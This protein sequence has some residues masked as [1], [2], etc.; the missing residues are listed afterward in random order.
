MVARESQTSCRNIHAGIKILDYDAFPGLHLIEVVPTMVLVEFN[1]VVL[2][3]VM[4]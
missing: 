1:E 2:S 3:Y 4:G